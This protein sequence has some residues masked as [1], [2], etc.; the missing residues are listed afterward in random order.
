M[1][2]RE[3]IMGNNKR[4]SESADGPDSEI[5][6]HH[7]EASG[8]GGLSRR[9]LLAATT[10]G[11]AAGAL[12]TSGLAGALAAQPSQVPPANAQGN[13]QSIVLKGGVVLTMD[14]QKG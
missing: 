9:E 2:N 10:A 8:K 12:L 5:H 14:P 7:K 6:D 1:S 3:V 4:P 13:G 11:A